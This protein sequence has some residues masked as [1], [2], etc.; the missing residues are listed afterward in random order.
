MT[1]TAPAPQ[2]GQYFDVPGIGGGTQWTL[3]D[4]TTVSLSTTLSSSG[5]TTA[6]GI[7]PLKATDVVIDWEWDLAIAATYTPGTSTFTDSQYAPF[8]FVGPTKVLIQNQYA[9]VDVENGIDL[10]VFGLIR[11]WQENNVRLNYYA[12]PAGF[13]AGSTALGYPAVGLAQPNLIAPN[14]WAN[15]SANLQTL[16]RL[17]ASITFDLYWDLDVYGRP[18]GAPPHAAIVSPQFMAGATRQIIPQVT[19]NQILSIGA[20][21]SR[22]TTPTTGT[23]GNGT[24]TATATTTFRRNAIYASDPTMLPPVYAWQ[25]RWRTQRFTLSGVQTTK[26]LV[27]QDSGQILCLY[28]RMWDPTANA[29]NGGAIPLANLSRIQVQYGSG[30]FAFDGT[31]KQLQ[32]DFLKKH[33]F[34]LPAGVICLDLM[35]DERN[36]RTN[37]RALNTLTTA[38]ILVSLTFTGAQSASAYAVMGIESLVYVS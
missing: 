11:P 9:S 16:L 29:N 22:D 25:Y 5:Q 10:Y 32:A 35:L 30:L 31:P 20:T 17:P 27:P 8:N 28:V 23:A 6:N 33:G 15:T 12:N 26:L 36:N 2:P 19:F 4:E 38:G 3:Q 18:T 1:Q 13:A 14:Q 7:L 34:L 24:A 21:G 37:K